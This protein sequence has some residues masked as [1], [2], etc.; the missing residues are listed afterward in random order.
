MTLTY[1]RFTTHFSK[2]DSLIMA[3]IK[4]VICFQQTTNTR[5][6]H[7]RCLG[8]RICLSVFDL[9]YVMW[10]KVLFWIRAQHFIARNKLHFALMWRKNIAFQDHV[11]FYCNIRTSNKFPLTECYC[12]KLYSFF[13][14][15]S[16]LIFECGFVTL[17]NYASIT[18]KHTIL[19]TLIIG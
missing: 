5:L 1:W 10:K 14:R 7:S 19:F 18:S 17:I 9:I 4:L 16:Y 11:L 15:K 12:V 8:P 6:H 13:C 2:V 3:T